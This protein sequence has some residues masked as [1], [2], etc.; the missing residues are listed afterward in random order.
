MTNYYSSS[1]KVFRIPNSA[2]VSNFK[3]KEN[4]FK[5]YKKAMYI[6]IYIYFMAFHGQDLVPCRNLHVRISSAL[7]EFLITH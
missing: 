3:H 1:D 5:L 7:S 2:I 6:S 4:N